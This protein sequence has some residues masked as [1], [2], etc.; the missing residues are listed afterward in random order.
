MWHYALDRT[1]HLFLNQPCEYITNISK[2]WT[3]SRGQSGQIRCPSAKDGGVGVYRW[4]T[5][6]IWPASGGQL[7]DLIAAYICLGRWMSHS[8]SCRKPGCCCSIQR[9]EAWPAGPV[10]TLKADEIN[11]NVTSVSFLAN[12]FNIKIF[13]HSLSPH[14]P[15]GLWLW[16]IRLQRA[17][18]F[19]HGDSR[20]SGG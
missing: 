16:L 13:T 12:S 9:S 7:A 2:R 11:L 20:G 18:V 1:A 19:S 10:S 3:L 6:K 17:W 15:Q 4:P 8:R 5:V 14:C